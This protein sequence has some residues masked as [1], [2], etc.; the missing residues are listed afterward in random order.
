[1]LTWKKPDGS[2]IGAS[3]GL[4]LGF[5]GDDTLGKFLVFDRSCYKDSF[6]SNVFSLG[7][8][9]LKIVPANDIA[10]VNRRWFRDDHRTK[11]RDLVF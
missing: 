6:K 5:F 11:P 7:I 8:H 1:M 9:D 4:F 2:A 10:S 3:E